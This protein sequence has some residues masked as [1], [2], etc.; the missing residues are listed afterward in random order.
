MIARSMAS[1]AWVVSAPDAPWPPTPPL[2]S[3]LSCR[4]LS[5]SSVPV[6]FWPG[7]GWSR[8]RSSCTHNRTR[9]SSASGL[10][11]PVTYGAIAA[12]HATAWA[13]SPS[14]HAPP[15]LPPAEAPARRPAH[16]A[17]NCSVH[18]SSSAELP[19]S[20]SRSASEICA[21][22]LTGC[23][24]R[25]GSSPAA[26]SRCMRR[27]GFCVMIDS[28][29]APMPTGR[30]PSSG[31]ACMPSERNLWTFADFEAGGARVWAPERDPVPKVAGRVLQGSAHITRQSC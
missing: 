8:R 19:S 25:S 31:Q 28:W 14:S 27:L 12:S 17:R 29:T 3:A 18:S 13:A 2:G 30:K 7:R 26:T 11:S 1:H 23:P 22:T 24:A 15:M 4:M 5:S 9:S 10:T 6:S 20:I 16:R 21:T